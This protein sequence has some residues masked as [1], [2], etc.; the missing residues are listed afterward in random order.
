MSLIKNSKNRTPLLKKKKS[1]KKGMF[2]VRYAVLFEVFFRFLLISNFC[3]TVHHVL[4][5]LFRTFIPNFETNSSP[6]IVNAFLRLFYRII[7]DRFRSFILSYRATPLVIIQIVTN[8]RRTCIPASK[9]NLHRHFWAHRVITRNTH[10]CQAAW[11]R[12]H[13]RRQYLYVILRLLRYS[14]YR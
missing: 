2:H 8:H 9:I 6:Y 7:F 10:E 5:R 14:P 3:S 11:V 1:E 13:A 4:N 12:C